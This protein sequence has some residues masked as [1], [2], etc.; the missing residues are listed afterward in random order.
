MSY[1]SADTDLDENSEAQAPEEDEIAISPTKTI[2]FSMKYQ[3]RL[4]KSGRWNYSQSNPHPAEVMAMAKA[5][6]SAWMNAQIDADEVKW[7]LEILYKSGPQYEAERFMYKTSF[8]KKYVAKGEG[9]RKSWEG[10]FKDSMK[11]WRSMKELDVLHPIRQSRVQRWHLFEKICLLATAFSGLDVAESSG[12]FEKSLY[13][14]FGTVAPY[15]NDAERMMASARYAHESGD[16][17]T[18]ELLF[19]DLQVLWEK[20]RTGLIQGADD[21]VSNVVNQPSVNMMGSITAR[22]LLSA[23]RQERLTWPAIRVGPSFAAD[24]LVENDGVY[25]FAGD[26]DYTIYQRIHPVHVSMS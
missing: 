26:E 21:A 6:R 2:E 15:N 22:K 24:D 10:A 16:V 8:E 9:P 17:E 25:R 20:Y 23:R 12:R 19:D 3:T 5:V 1:A 14:Y 13:A 4:I 11:S 7:T 18:L